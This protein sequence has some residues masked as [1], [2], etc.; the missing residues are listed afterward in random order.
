MDAKLAKGLARSFIQTLKPFTDT[1]SG[2]LAPPITAVM[3]DYR[4]GGIS[5]SS[6]VGYG[7]KLREQ[8]DA[9]GK[10]PSSCHIVRHPTRKR[11]IV[12]SI[13]PA[14]VEGRDQP[15]IAFASTVFDMTPDELVLIET[16]GHV[17]I[18]RH[19]MSRLFERSIFREDTFVALMTA[20]TRW[21]APLLMVN[22]RA[23]WTPGANVAMPYLGG[24]LLGTVEPNPIESEQG[25]TAASISKKG[26]DVGYLE[27]PFG[28]I[29]SG[30]M[31]IGINT[32][33]GP[34][35]LY[36]DQRLLVAA[37]EDFERRFA[38]AMTALRSGMVKGLPD[39]RMLQRFG[40]VLE[41]IDT[42]EL[43]SLLQIL[44]RLRATP[45]WKKHS[46]SHHRHAR[47]LH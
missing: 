40:A 32:Y 26:V 30:V 3:Q 18:S 13:R 16:T 5:K 43:L 37:F 47:Y 8:L 44:E 42:D 12:E 6:L 24:L 33:V 21:T 17:A 11:A 10:C 19:T 22:Q 25:P 7:L 45:D 41:T 34:H 28:Q 2:P 35:D 31:V 1:S 27:P 46:D 36:D 15:W 29:G 4:N 14:V 39:R 23:G 9:T 38:E 20:A